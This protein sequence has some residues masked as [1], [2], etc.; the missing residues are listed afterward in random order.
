LKI[1][2]EKREKKEGLGTPQTL[3]NLILA[4][5]GVQFSHIAPGTKNRQKSDQ[6]GSKM[7]PKWSQGHQKEPPETSP[8]LDTKKVSKNES[9]G[10]L[11]INLS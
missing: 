1:E 3:E 5:E 8:K 6:N 10:S 2:A 4:A 9:T 11:E 7:N